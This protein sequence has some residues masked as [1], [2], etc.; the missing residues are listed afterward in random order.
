MYRKL[1]PDLDITVDDRNSRYVIE[2]AVGYVKFC[3]FILSANGQQR[4]RTIKLIKSA[5]DIPYTIIQL[6]KAYSK[7]NGIYNG[8]IADDGIIRSKRITNDKILHVLF[9][10]NYCLTPSLHKKTL[11][12]SSASKIE[13][14]FSG[15]YY[16]YHTK[17]RIT[18]YHY[19]LYLFLNN[20]MT[21]SLFRFYS[22]YKNVETDMEITFE[23]GDLPKIGSDKRASCDY[24]FDSEE[25][26]LI[27]HGG[28]IVSIINETFRKTP[29]GKFM[30]DIIYRASGI[31]NG[32]SNIILS[33]IEF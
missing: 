15:Y 10:I 2:F 19:G 13:G 12:G 27:K 9:D 24:S 1:L 4:L 20:D 25:H 8:F 29:L 31:T 23:L 11:L 28:W 22:N 17:R 16:K 21:F 30:N 7:D 32:P 6:F 33:Y 18:K 5:E 3:K 26:I 14:S